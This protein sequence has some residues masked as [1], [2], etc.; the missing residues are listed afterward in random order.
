MSTIAVA[1]SP[2]S[3]AAVWVVEWGNSV[4]GR[5]SVLW[6]VLAF[7]QRLL[8]SLFQSLSSRFLKLE[9]RL[10]RILCPPLLPLSVSPSS[11]PPPLPHTL[12]QAW[13]LRESATSLGMWMSRL[14]NTCA[15]AGEGE[16][17]REGRR[18]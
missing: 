10:I 11:L 8:V 6:S 14:M 3:F 7:Q 4:G 18:E 13:S 2:L 5:E 12:S 16:R 17:E 1:C 15:P 9:P